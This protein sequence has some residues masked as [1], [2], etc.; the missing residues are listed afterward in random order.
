[1]PH[2]M[3][4]LSKEKFTKPL[5]TLIIGSSLCVFEKDSHP[6]NQFVLGEEITITNGMH[7]YEI[8]LFQNGRIIGPSPPSIEQP[9]NEVSENFENAYEVRILEIEE[10]LQKEEAK[11]APVQ[12]GGVRA[13]ANVWP[14]S[15][16][17]CGGDY[18]PC[19]VVD[20]ES[21]GDYNAVNPDGCGGRTCGGKWQ[22]DPKT[23]N[24]YGG[25]SYAQDAPPKLQDEKAREIWAGG[26]GCS[27]WNACEK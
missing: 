21:D 27:H 12:N 8:N 19:W 9:V 4:F 2:Y 13:A 22:F 14:A 15:F 25:F 3:S 26:N 18:P 24:N 5:A 10:E 1:M 23:W 17:T 6:S 20:A 11:L 7:Q 16:E